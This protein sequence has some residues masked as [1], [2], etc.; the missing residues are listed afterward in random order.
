MDFMVRTLLEEYEKWG[1]N[2]NIETLFTW[3][4][5]GETKY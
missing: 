3:V 2:I 5:G 4:C 1:L